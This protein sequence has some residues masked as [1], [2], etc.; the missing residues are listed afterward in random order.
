MRSVLFGNG[1]VIQYGGKDY[2]NARIVQRA[3]DNIRSGGFPAHLYPKECADFVVA[4]QREHSAALHGKYDKHA[5][6]SYDRS[7]LTDFKKRYDINRLYSATE[8]GF[9]DYFLLFELVCN[10]QGTGNPERFHCRGVLRRMFLDAVFNSGKIETVYRQFHNEFVEWLRENDHIFTTNYDSN[11]DSAS[12]MNVHHLHGSFKTISETYNSDSF[13]NQL[14]EDL[15]NG[16]KVDPAYP[17]LYSNCLVSHVGDIKSYSMTQPSLANS[18]M[19]KFVA[20]YQNDPEIKRQIDEMD[21][22]ND[23]TRRLKQAIRLK[24][25][26]PNLK[27]SE[28]YP[29]KLLKEISGPLQIVGLSP[30]NDGHL[31]KEIL[32]NQKITEIIFNHYEEQEIADAQRLFASKNLILKDVRDFWADYAS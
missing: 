4:L 18:G 30:N 24:A 14:K 26:Q 31:F 19:E 23:L 29:H 7:S 6:T 16:E 9:E 21:E 1:I 2:L 11:L 22:S 3:L 32:D 5:H 28:H 17:H 27:H 10:S 15:L 20:G 8:I 13:R 25:E 12:G